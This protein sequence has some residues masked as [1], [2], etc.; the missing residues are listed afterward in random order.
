M[1]DLAEVARMLSTGMVKGMAEGVLLLHQRLEPPR[2]CACG[3]FELGQSH[4]RHQAE[5]L[6]RLGLLK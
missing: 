1:T 6:Q 5:E 3:W 2:G 4:A